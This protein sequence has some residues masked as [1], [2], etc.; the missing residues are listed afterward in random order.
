[1]N[2]PYRNSFLLFHVLKTLNMFLTFKKCLTFKK[3]SLEFIHRKLNGGKLNFLM[4]TEQKEQKYS[5]TFS[6]TKIIELL[7]KIQIF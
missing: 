4:M 2:T 6:E 7:R 5:P 3:K 1:M